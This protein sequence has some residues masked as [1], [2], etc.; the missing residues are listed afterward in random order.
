MIKI[1]EEF[2]Y[3][4]DINKIISELK[5]FMNKNSFPRNKW[6]YSDNMKIYVRKS[7]RFIEGELRDFLD[8][9]TIEVEPKGE[10]LFTKLLN[11]IEKTFPNTNLYLESILNDRL[12]D[13][14]LRNNF[15][16]S[17]SET[18]KNVYKIK[19]I[20]NYSEQID[21]SKYS[22]ITGL[23]QD[24][25][26][27]EGKGIPNVLKWL[28]KKI[29]EDLISNNNITI[30]VDEPDFKLKNLNIYFGNE[31]YSTFGKFKNNYLE[32]AEISI[33]KEY[34]EKEIKRTII[35]ELTHIY[36]IYH[37]IMNK[38]DKHLQWDILQ[39]L[40]FL[41]KK[42]NNDQFLKD[43]SLMI[44]SSTDVE[45]NATISQ[46]YPYLIDLKTDNKDEIEKEL[47][48]TLTWTRLIELKH[49]NYKDYNVNYDKCIKYFE[50]LN[51]NIKTNQN[52]NLF[53]IP[54]NKKDVIDILNNYQKLFKKKTD[55]LEKKINKVIQEVIIDVKQLNESY[56]E[57][58]I[59]IKPNR[60]VIE[61]KI[62]LKNI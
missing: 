62:K 6:I 60:K 46:I 53:K 45:L 32:N 28:Y 50:F 51:S 31:S 18:D 43:L 15:K 49:F 55:Y 40:Q 44:Y 37:R 7:K 57:N 52:F 2:K 34:S 26:I 12:Y 9:A 8:L 61:R 48:K 11:E 21:Y 1:F 24:P 10:G 47:K 20:F 29:F 59:L 4:K 36:E 16:D 35:H 23:Y 3:Q 30:N 22:Y 58:N 41:I 13:F 14:L 38:T 42:Y 54:E 33:K 17:G 19:N 56:F 27:Y 25:Y 39:L 5:E